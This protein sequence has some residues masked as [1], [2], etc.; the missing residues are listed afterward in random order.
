MKYQNII[1][2]EF[3]E[4]INR[5]VATVKID[6]KL[7]KVHVKNTGRC[8]ELFIKGA[9]VFLEDHFSNMRQRKLRYSLISVIKD[10]RVIINVDS[11]IPNKVVEEGIRNNIIRLPNLVP[12]ISLKSE[13][14][15]RNSRF[16]FFAED[17]KGQ[18]AFIEVKGVTL[19]NNGVA[20]FPDAPTQRGAKHIN[21]LISALDDNYKSYIILVIQMKGVHQFTPNNVTDINFSQ[22]LKLAEERGVH[23]MAF[24]CNVTPDNINADKQISILLE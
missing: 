19:E 21:E 23:I 11:Q 4:R 6:G 24:D 16:D 20:M 3:V 7:E 5:F 8:K 12:P 1:Q 2:G 17:S 22:A 13:Q 9:T 15:Y 10:N 14:T 18:K